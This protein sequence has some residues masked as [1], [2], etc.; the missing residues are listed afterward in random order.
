MNVRITCVF[1]YFDSLI[2]GTFQISLRL[3][4]AKHVEDGG[5]PDFQVP[6]TLSFSLCIRTSMP[7]W[8]RGPFAT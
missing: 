1:E 7:T 5:K 8:V 2:I 3:Q 4:L 6:T